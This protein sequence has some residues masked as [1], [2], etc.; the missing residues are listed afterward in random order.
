M[1]IHLHKTFL[2]RKLFKGGNYSRKYSSW[3][4]SNQKKKSCRLDFVTCTAQV[5]HELWPHLGVSDRFQLGH[6]GRQRIVSDRHLVWNFSLDYFSWIVHWEFH[7]LMT[8]CVQINWA[9]ECRV[10]SLN[11]SLCIADHCRNQRN[12]WKKRKRELFHYTIFRFIIL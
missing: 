9:T 3:K 6:L 12:R 11:F 7:L 4:I 2:L 1:K 8:C 5:W 10:Q